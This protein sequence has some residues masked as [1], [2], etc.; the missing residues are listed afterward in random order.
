MLTASHISTQVKTLGSHQLLQKEAREE[1][2]KKRQEQKLALKSTAL[3]K[4]YAEDS[5]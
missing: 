3:P 5:Q 2:A 1:A 4:I